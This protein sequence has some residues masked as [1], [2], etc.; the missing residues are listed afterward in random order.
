MTVVD[1]LAQALVLL[2]GTFAALSGIGLAGAGLFNPRVGTWGQYA[3]A[4]CA[5][6]SA[7]Y[8]LSYGLGEFPRGA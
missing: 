7:F 4:A 2:L 3:L 8:L 6:V 5:F 1:Y